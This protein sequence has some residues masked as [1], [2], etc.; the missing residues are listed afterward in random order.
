MGPTAHCP[1]DRP[2]PHFPLRVET[3]TRETLAELA[4][5]AAAIAHGVAHERGPIDL[6]AAVSR[7]IDAA[8]RRALTL[9]NAGG[10][11]DESARA[12]ALGFL[13]DATALL[14]LD[15]HLAP[16]EAAALVDGA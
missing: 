11:S 15:G 2:K 13:A 12:A 8:E 10:E 16:G 1:R 14:A 3:S 7:R 5:R 9:A 6:P 4:L